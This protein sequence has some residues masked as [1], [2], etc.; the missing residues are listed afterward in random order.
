MI[1]HHWQAYNTVGNWSFAEDGS[2]LVF[3]SETDNEMS[4]L[5]IGSHEVYEAL[6]CRADGVP[7]AAVDEWDR[8]HADNDEPGAMEGSPY[9]EQ[10]LAAERIERLIIQESGDTWEAHEARIDAL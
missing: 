10:H 1:P 5:A 8:L 6:A 7:E 4:N 3:V 9:R 2:L